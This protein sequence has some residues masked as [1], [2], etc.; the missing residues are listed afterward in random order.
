MEGARLGFGTLLG[1]A[2]VLLLSLAA[3]A[4]QPGA[5]A[6]D[7]QHMQSNFAHYRDDRTPRPAIQGLDAEGRIAR[8]SG[9]PPPTQVP[10]LL[11]KISP[12]EWRPG[13]PRSVSGG[14]GTSGLSASSF[15]WSTDTAAPDRS[16]GVRNQSSS[17]GLVQRGSRR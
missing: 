3:R 15:S 5:V 16:S 2:P 9:A 11:L 7:D 13:G 4:E 17:L 1:V 14:A 6:W 12:H 10:E 8:D